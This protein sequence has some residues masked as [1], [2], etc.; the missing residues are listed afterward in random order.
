[1]KRGRTNSFDMGA[2][3]PTLNRTRSL[4]ASIQS[5]DITA[6]RRAAQ[7]PGCEVTLAPGQYILHS[8]LVVASGVVLKAI[9]PAATEIIMPTQHPDFVAVRNFAVKKI[10]IRKKPPQLYGTAGAAA[11]AAAAASAVRT[12]SP[13]ARGK[14]AQPRRFR[15]FRR[16][17][18]LAPM[19]SGAPMQGGAPMQPQGWS[20]QPSSA[21]QL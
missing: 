15:R 4:R 2:E 17:S 18:G 21:M 19:Q 20:P 10:Q 3:Q 14:L 5:G 9:H 8:Q 16:Q 6:L 13:R 12:G 11:T 1:M 7:T